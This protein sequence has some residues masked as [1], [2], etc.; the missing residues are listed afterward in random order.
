MSCWLIYGI[1]SDTPGTFT[2]FFV[3]I[4]PL[5]STRQRISRA[6]VSSTVRRTSP[7]SSRIVSPAWTSCGSSL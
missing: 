1:E 3:F 4:S 7:S 2:P 5:F 6:V